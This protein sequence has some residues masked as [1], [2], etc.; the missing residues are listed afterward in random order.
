MIIVRDGN[1]RSGLAKGSKPPTSH[2][3][4]VQ[5]DITSCIATSGIG[6]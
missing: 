1:R 3:W 6:E 5:K 4:I 2:C